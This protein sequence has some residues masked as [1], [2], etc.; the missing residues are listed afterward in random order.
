MKK[1]LLKLSTLAF[2]FSILLSISSCRDA[3]ENIDSVTTSE[4][5]GNLA[6]KIQSFRNVEEKKVLVEF[7]NFINSQASQNIE[8]NAIFFHEQKLKSIYKER[9]EFHFTSIQ[10]LAD[11]INSLVLIDKEKSEK[12][13]TSYSKFLRKSIY[14]VEPTVNYEDAITL[15]ISKL[16]KTNDPTGKYIGVVSVKEGILLTNGAYSITWH[17]GIEKHKDDLGTTFYR[18]FT[19]IGSNVQINGQW[20]TYPS[21]MRPSLD[22][23]A[24]FFGASIYHHEMLGFLSD[25]GSVIRNTGQKTDY[26]WAPKSARIGG[27]FTTTVNGAEYSLEGASN[28]TW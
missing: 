18:N 5:N 3:S 23:R 13:F 22:S 9:Q 16:T 8:K 2:T 10:N 17:V 4:V 21:S 24:D 25:Y 20:T 11:E 26:G 27:T 14:T 28:F 7:K 6:N 1:K 12:L 19:Q 15:D